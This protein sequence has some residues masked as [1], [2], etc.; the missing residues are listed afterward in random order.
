MYGPP[1]CGLGYR[2]TITHHKIAVWPCIVERIVLTFILR[3]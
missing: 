3:K 1:A 2:L